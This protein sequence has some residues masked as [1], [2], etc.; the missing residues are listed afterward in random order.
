ME[1]KPPLFIAEIS[2]NHLGDLNRARQLVHAAIEAGASA[3]KFQ[4]YTAETMTLNIDIEEF[5]I[6]SEH[7]LWGGRKLY[8][9]Y[10]EAHTPWS[11][12]EELFDICRK[13]NVIP[14]SSPFDVTAVD[15]LETL[16]APMYKIASM[17]TGDHTLIRRVAE[18]GKPLIIS[19]GAT[20][21]KEIDEL[22][23]VVEKTGNND[24]TLLVCT[25]SYPAD[26]VDAH[27]RRIDTLRDR[28]GVKVGVSDH[29][30][31][32][33]VSIAAIALGATFVEKHFTLRRKDGGADGDF[34]M[35]P[36]EFAT[37]V[38]EGRSAHLALGNPK[39]SM[40]YSERESRRIRRSLYVVQDVRAGEMITEE[41]VRAIR[42]GGGCAPKLFDGML[43]MRFSTDLKAGTPMAQNLARD[44]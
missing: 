9:L 43:G 44:F 40:Q 35:E 11:W 34:S 7:P 30:L 16:D 27:L 4:T 13:A 31:G 10:E 38:K 1:Y 14:F 42:P 15:F 12:H 18:T 28:F 20:E 26:P 36:Q 29:T 32:I 22:V 39:W 33:G 19:T 37:L 8:E 17:E 23:E 25:S 21:L 24:L 41:N 5:R 6:S 2:A 3:I